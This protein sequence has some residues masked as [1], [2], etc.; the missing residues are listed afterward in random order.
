MDR[1]DLERP[2]KDGERRFCF[3]N[4]WSGGQPGEVLLG[5]DEDDVYVLRFIVQWYGPYTL[6][7]VARKMA[8]LRSDDLPNK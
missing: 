7:V 3:G 4:W 5:F 1:H 2:L 8:R 6:K